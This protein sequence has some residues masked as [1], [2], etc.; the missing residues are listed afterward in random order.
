MEIHIVNLSGATT[1]E[2]AL[3]G[4]EGVNNGSDLSILQPGD[5]HKILLGATI[6]K[7]R[8]LTAIGEYIA[9]GQS[10]TATT[11]MVDIKTHLRAPAPLRAEKKVHASYSRQSSKRLK[12]FFMHLKKMD[13]V[14]LIF[15]M[16]IAACVAQILYSLTVIKFLENDKFT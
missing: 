1:A 3:L 15:S 4:V 6:T 14:K 9:R 13:R 11:T 2:I 12:T 10:V 7:I 16:A 5:I 8:K